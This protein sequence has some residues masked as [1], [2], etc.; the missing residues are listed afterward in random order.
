[1]PGEVAGELPGDATGARAAAKC[2]VER[3]A[4]TGGD[5]RLADAE[6]S[7]PVPDDGEV[8]VLAEGVEGNPQPEAFGE[9]D[10]FLD[11]LAGV[12]FVIDALG[13][14]VFGEVFGR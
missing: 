14:A 12:D 9:R 5:D 11:G 4:F 13:V 7:R 2:P 3:I 1:M 10:F 8:I 6:L